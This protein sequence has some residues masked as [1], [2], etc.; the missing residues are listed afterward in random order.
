MRRILELEQQNEMLRRRLQQLLG[1][2]TP[3]KF[4]DAAV[5]HDG[6]GDAGERSQGSGEWDGTPKAISAPVMQI[7]D[8]REAAIVSKL[9]AVIQHLQQE[10]A[11]SA[12]SAVNCSGDVN[13][14]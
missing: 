13:E 6:V 14:Y 11:R 1:R 3:G 8:Q 7:E 5:Q 12:N 4:V 2:E 10:I 9:G